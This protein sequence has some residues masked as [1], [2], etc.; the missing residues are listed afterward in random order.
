[1]HSEYRP[2]RVKNFLMYSAAAV[3]LAASGSP[4]FAQDVDV[5][6]SISGVDDIVVTARRKEE[7]NQ[8]VPVA[9]TAFG[10]ERLNEMRVVDTQSLQ[11]IVPSLIVGGNGQ[12][13][14]DSQAL[15]IR[16][17]GATFQANPSVVVYMAEAPL[18]GTITISA[19]GGPGNYLDLQNVQVLKGPQG[20]LFGRNTTGGALL[21]SPQRP[22]DRMEGYIQVQGGNYN[23]R[24]VQVVANV[25]VIE[26]KLL[27]RF[28]GEVVDRDGYTKDI[29]W[30]KDRDDRHYWTGRLGVTWRPTEK[31]ENYLMAYNTWSRNNGAGQVGKG[32]NLAAYG[33]PAEAPYFGYNQCD[34]GTGI[35]FANP[36]GPCSAYQA[37]IDAQNARGN[38]KVSHN[39]DSFS[40]I[41][42]WGVTDILDLQL[43]EN[44]TLRNIANYAEI[45]SY[46]ATDGDGYNLPSYDV[47]PFNARGLPRDDIRQYSEELQLQG[48]ALEGR[49]E[50][51][52]G[53]FY[54]KNEPNGDQGG[55]SI[56]VCPLAY[57]AFC[58]DAG[59][60]GD[61]AFNTFNGRSVYGV[62]NESYAAYAQGTY[63]LGG[64]TEALDGLRLTLG[65]RYTTDKVDG[66]SQFYKFNGAGY[67]CTAT[68]IVV[69]DPADCRFE[70][71][72]KNSQPTWTAGLDYKLQPDLL[73]YG[74]VS[75]GYKAGGFNTY[76]VRLETRT[77]GPEKVVS[78][79]AGM[80][81]DFT[82]QDM[83]LRLN[84]TVFQTDYDSIQRAAGDAREIAPGSFVSGAQILSTAEARIRGIEIESVI[85]PIPP[86]ELGVNYSHLDS[87]YT[88]YEYDVPAGAVLVGDCDGNSFISGATANLKC[89]PLQYISPNIVN[90]YG[91][92]NFTP[93]MSLF[94]NYSWSDDQHTE[95]LNI[96]TNQ[97]GERI[98]SYSL[99]SA[100]FDWK[101]VSGSAIDLSLFATN[102]LD[103]EYR[104]SN[105]NVY[106]TGSLGAWSTLYGEPR[107]FG[108]RLR[109]NWGG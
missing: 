83:P 87:K 22:T 66:F 43:T 99:L 93:D 71:K 30:N 42:T 36:V 15:S 74:K 21:L 18:P 57:A 104:I 60:T 8:D 7:R 70:E 96:E 34:P 75:K 5:Q 79:E 101:R 92:Y 31:I 65:Y 97:P 98:A 37:E 69:A 55:T 91:R 39:T 25:P 102:I 35:P 88:K 53:G 62:T 67:T 2:R 54:F 41:K 12:G 61:G 40:K 52:L 32:I 85:K 78:Y 94:V 59:P 13:S 50:Y 80:K 46:L 4:A 3:A 109:Y 77:F 105:T 73:V 23:D 47:N 82:V 33:L 107:I 72:S 56:S 1:M 28:A 49:L 17:Q 51:V 76:A 103:E 19:Q 90:V 106:E 27:M 14:R 89:L 45:K 108:A 58:N 44:L 9:I 16:G 38:R 26:D 6:T 29:N 48:K 68:G 95:A 84:V 20:T 86:L 64:F 100:S 63:D 11:S 81:S 10:N 24:E